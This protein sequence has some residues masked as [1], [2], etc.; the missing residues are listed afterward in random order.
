MLLQL[1]IRNYA[2]IDEI[3]LDFDPS[4]NVLTGETGA[5]KSI[6]LD[7]LH[8]VLG[9]RAG[10]ETLRSKDIPCVIEAAF[11]LP[12]GFVFSEDM[13]G[14]AEEG[15][16]ALL[17]RREISPDGRSRS[18]INRKVVNLSALK[19]LGAR[20][21]DFHGQHD[22]QQI[23]E[24]E[25][26]RELVDRLAGLSSTHALVL[27]YKKNF[28]EYTQLIRKR[29]E[30][31]QAEE[32]RQ[33]KIDLLKYQIDEIER[34]NPE[35][36]EE[37]SLQ[38]EKIRLSHAQK[39]SDLTGEILDA[40][41][42][43]DTAASSR[44]AGVF[45]GFQSWAKIDPAAD[46][47]RG[48]LEDIQINLEELNRQIRDYR[49]S[50]SFDEERLGEI[51]RRVDGL[52]N[53][54][55]KYGGTVARVREFLET[56][57][58]EYDQLVNAEVYQ[59]DAERGISK[60]LPALKKCSEQVSSLRAKAAK[61]IQGE[62]ERELKDLGMMHA[63][64]ECRLESIPFSENGSETVEFFFTPNP[65]HE[66]KPLVKVASGGEASRVLLALKRALA[67]VDSTPT[68]IFD[69]IDSNI[70]GRLGEIVGRKLKEI[71]AERQVLLITHLPQIASFSTRHFKV[72]KSV[73]KG[74]TRVRYELLEGEEKVRELAQ[75][76]SGLKES[77][78]ARTHAKEMLKSAS[79]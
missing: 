47:M 1:S 34:L 14:L 64:F 36:D 16:D 11:S 18:F 9:E 17:L 10:A 7:A 6:L 19:D 61:K 50:L 41:D 48:S 62:V 2:L 65:G 15:D 76:M 73:A 46:V 70:G 43:G 75:M 30:I 32:G 5:G 53:L 77:D 21:V 78:I 52:E 58:Q 56:S 71:S 26:H 8:L 24:R 57:R 4:L 12:E 28:E 63:R 23:F 35:E 49:E 74:E 20:L 51:E 69:E 38:S 55:R 31:L 29:D 3:T 27:D 66:L 40:L 22:Q 37:E 44:I 72:I 54:K 79:N 13:A 39:L 68:L 42:S 45:R 25:T 67:K 59:K 33:R 60:I